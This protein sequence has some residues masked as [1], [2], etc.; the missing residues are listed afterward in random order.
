MEALLA[1]LLSTNQAASTSAPAFQGQLDAAS[2]SSSSP[3]ALAFDAGQAYQRAM[4]EHSNATK[5]FAAAQQA[6][7][8]Q[9]QL[10]TWMSSK[11]V[12][13]ESVVEKK[14]APQVSMASD[15][16]YVQEKLD[17]RLEEQWKEDNTYIAN[18][19]AMQA[20]E[21]DKH[22]GKPDLPKQDN[23]PKAKAMP[24]K[25][26]RLGCLD[27]PAGTLELYCRLLPK[28]VV[29]VDNDEIEQ[30]PATDS[31]NSSEPVGGKPVQPPG[32]PPQLRQINKPPPPVPVMGGVD[33]KR[34]SCDY[35]YVSAHQCSKSS[36]N[37]IIAA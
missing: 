25:M 2:S 6:Q 9:Q 20:G 11:T 21:K 32:P 17:P 27:V 5:M 30:F 10:N 22:E 31:K 1:A 12:P 8:L 34:L 13:A 28:R 24:V 37:L 26:Q 14:V 29:D 7:Q 36:Q 18:Y 19:K 33:K 4:N 16:N 15:A 35:L 3:S 23:P